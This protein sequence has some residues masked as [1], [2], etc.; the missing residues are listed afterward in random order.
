M[1]SVDGA[2][3]SNL[4]KNG[5]EGEMECKKEET[6]KEGKLNEKQNSE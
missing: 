2:W 5:Q 4:W 3:K 1:V 6:I